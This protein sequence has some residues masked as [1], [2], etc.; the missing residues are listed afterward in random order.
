[1][2]TDWKTKQGRNYKWAFLYYLDWLENSTRVKV[3]V[4]IFVLFRLI[5]NYTREKVQISIFVFRLTEN[6]TRE[7]VQ[8]IIVVLYLDWLKSY[9]FPFYF[10]NYRVKITSQYLC[11]LFKAWILLISIW[12]FWGFSKADQSCNL[13]KMNNFFCLFITDQKSHLRCIE[14]STLTSCESLFIIHL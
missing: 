4:R 7:K 5:E 13:L 9:K 10:K 8:I 11:I 2:Q 12:L 3:Q 14:L 1:M 6:Y